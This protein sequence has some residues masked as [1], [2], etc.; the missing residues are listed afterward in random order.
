MAVKVQLIDRFS[1]E[2]KILRNSTPAVIVFYS[3][4]CPSCKA[5]LSKL[6]IL[7]S[8][9][10]CNIDFYKILRKDAGYLNEKYCI[11]SIPTTLLFN[12]GI[13]ISKGIVG[14]ASRNEIISLIKPF[15]NNNSMTEKIKKVSCDVLII[16]G[17]P[18]GLSSAIYSSREGLNTIVLEESLPGGKLLST[19]NIENYPGIGTIKGK[20]LAKNMLLQAK[21][22]GTVIHSLETLKSISLLPYTKRISTESTEYEAKTVII[23]TGAEPRR[24]P[25][26][27]ESR[28]YGKGVHYCAIC[29]GPLYKN[30]NIIVVGGGDSALKEAIFLSKYAERITI[31]H[32]F[33]NFQASKIIQEEILKNKRVSF[34]LNSEIRKI[35][36]KNSLSGTLIQ[37]TRTKAF[38]ELK[39]EGVFVYIG[40]SPKSDFLKGQVLLDENGYIIVDENMETNIKGVF[41][42]G[43]VR[44][45]SIRQVS[46][47]V[48]DGV[49]AALSAFGYLNS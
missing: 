21:S 4:N 43:D 46:T 6:E 23:A 2:D 45:K 40:L 34:V 39:A 3:E 17:G 20:T 12:N 18:A 47:A 7:L 1:F 25:A 33:E 19:E 38:R 5:F 42:A 22:F 27:D 9:L 16:G 30:K 29:D 41:A 11:K 8:R 44:R 24:L 26:E 10:S 15:L 37:D 36:G 32:Q 48:S 49:I 35:I 31:I 28:F 13:E 14:N